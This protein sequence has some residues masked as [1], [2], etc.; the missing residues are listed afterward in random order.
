MREDEK[1]EG[2]KLTAAQIA[3]FILG[4]ILFGVLMGIRGEF[5]SVWVRILIAASAG[6]VLAIIVL[7][8][9]KYR[10]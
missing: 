3:Q 6:A 7:P 1:P 10:R 5:D 9:R 4:I 2:P 8:L